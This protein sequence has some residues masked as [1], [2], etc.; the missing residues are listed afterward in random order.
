[1][2]RFGKGHGCV[3]SAS[4]CGAPRLSNTTGLFV[5]RQSLTLGLASQTD[6]EFCGCI[7]FTLAA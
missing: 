7:S 5:V 3:L 4:L 2:L 1:L 6:S